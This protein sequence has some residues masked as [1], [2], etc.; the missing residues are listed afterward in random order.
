MSTLAQCAI[1]TPGALLCLRCAELQLGEAQ[2]WAI[3]QAECTVTKSG[4]YADV[5]L[6]CDVR[7]LEDR[8]HAPC[9][10][11]VCGQAFL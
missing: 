2:A 7:R 5:L 4:D 10:C 3:W 11:S 6:A 9:L 1:W 8:Q